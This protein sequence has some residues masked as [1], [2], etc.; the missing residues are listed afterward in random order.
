MTAAVSAKLAL[1]IAERL[2]DVDVVARGLSQTARESLSGL[3][4]TALLHARLSA[5]DD[6]F[7]TAAVEHWNR[8]AIHI[9]Q[10][11]STGSGIF[12]G[13]GSVAA[14]LIIGASY[15][16]DAQ[17]LHDQCAA[18]AR[19]LSAHAI[20]IAEQQH[21]R[22]R[23]C[24]PPT[25]WAA[26][27]VICGLA[28]I[29]RVL[30]AAVDQG[31]EHVT[32]GLEA[33]LQTLTAMINSGSESRPGWWLPPDAH[34]SAAQVHPSG[35]A[36]TGTAHG[37]AG[38]LALLAVARI[39]GHDVPGQEKGIRAAADWLLRW[40]DPATEMW[41]PRITGYE[42]ECGKAAP[43]RGRHDAWCYGIPGIAV[44]LAQAARATSEDKYQVTAHQAMRSLAARGSPTWDVEGPT[45]CHGYAGILA[46]SDDHPG[47]AE[48]AARRI[49]TVA[50]PRHRYLVQHSERGALEDDPGLLTGAAGAALA[51]ADHAGL[52]SSATP[53]SRW[54]CILL[55]S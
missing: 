19:W 34:P 51:L 40:R 16:P 21:D 28:G 25:S 26:Y 41:P 49:E 35:A 32:I 38:P 37:I 55:L 54:N 3:S 6:C 42:L 15:L 50:N 5:V 10:R 43:V 7:A 52:P 18:A 48:L 30:M 46:A 29:G 13:L 22:L 27:D 11:G 12:T 53:A 33:A 14:S 24:E 4:G 36:A 17:R 45:L 8:L 9:R 47:L 2:L 20:A 1:A 23:S 31:H 39:A 44:A